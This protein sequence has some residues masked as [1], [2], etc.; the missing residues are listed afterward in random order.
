[1]SGQLRWQR[2]FTLTELLVVATLVALTALILAPSLGRVRQTNQTSACLA[3]LLQIGIA[4]QT[5]AAEDEDELIIPIHG[6]MVAATPYWEW[7]M[8]QWFAWGGSNPTLTVKLDPSRELWLSDEPPS[9]G[10]TIIWRPQYGASTRPL[11][12]YTAPEGLGMFHCPADTGYP[13]EPLWI[14]DAP[15][16]SAGR[17]CGDMLGNSYRANLCAVFDFSG[18]WSDG[19]RGVFSRGPWGHR[20]ST[21]TETSRLLLTADAMLFIQSGAGSAVPD[22]IACSWHGAWMTSNA[23]FCDGSARSVLTAP[24]QPGGLLF[25]EAEE[26]EG[27]AEPPPDPYPCVD[28]YLRFE[29]PRFQLD[30][31]PTPGA[32]IWGDWPVVGQSQCWPWAGAQD[33]LSD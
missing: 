17:P 5:Y 2:A 1:M 8:V 32:V 4:T 6:S 13:N 16:A 30:C 10:P 14:D 31:Y 11:N 18:G 23:L 33:N 9:S 12:G 29:L 7:R 21:L 24:R 26:V 27:A 25:E 19:P 20:L 3:N 15:I 28:D 22:S